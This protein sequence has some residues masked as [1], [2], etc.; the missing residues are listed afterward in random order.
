[1][2]KMTLDEIQAVNLEIMKEIHVFCVNN[3]INYSLAYGSLIGAIRHKGFIPWDDDIDIMMPHQ[4]YELFS[5]TFKSSK[6]YELLS[7][8]SN[9]TYVNYTRV[10][11]C[12]TIVKCPA[13]QCKHD[14]GIWV[15]VF[16]I[17]AIPDS[18]PEQKRQFDS[19]RHYTSL[20]MRYRVALRNLEENSFKRRFRGCLQITKLFLQN[21]GV[22]FKY[23]HNKVISI[24]NQYCF[25]KTKYCSSLVCVEANTYNKQ[26]VF[27]TSDF[28]HFSIVPFEDTSFYVV[29]AY[30]RVLHTIFG[31]YM[32]LP[33]KEK[34]VSHVLKKWSFYWK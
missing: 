27:L 19:L 32:Q 25:G 1:M 30:D 22:F 9:E 10:Y 26:E 33:P 16:P 24:C 31:D 3:H 8:Y 13:K 6:G 23:W 2:R 34:R 11:D 14:V 12:H 20:I 21:G 15:D 29:A 4:D 17:D 7:V 28:E 5:K 18:Q